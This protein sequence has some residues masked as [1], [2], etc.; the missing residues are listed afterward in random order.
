MLYCSLSLCIHGWCILLY[1]Q[2]GHT[3]VDTWSAS[4]RAPMEA[5]NNEVVALPNIEQ[6]RVVYVD[7]QLL[8][9]YVERRL[10]RGDH[11]IDVAETLGIGKR[12]LRRRLQLLG[13]RG[14]YDTPNVVSGDV[15]ERIHREV[16]VMRAG[17]NW[18]IRS[19]QCRLRLSGLR[20]GRQAVRDAMHTMHPEHMERRQLGRLRRGQYTITKP[21]ILWHMDCE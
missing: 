7:G 2:S 8:L 16:P 11:F 18:G 15:M 19:V 12:S 3:A 13:W 10:G 4:P 21:M 17:V 1:M 5:A 9:Q 20:V 6:T 14:V